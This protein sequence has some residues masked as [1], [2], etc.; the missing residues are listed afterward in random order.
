MSAP[1]QFQTLGRVLAMSASHLKA[2][3]PR[4]RAHVRS[5]PLAT[6]FLKRLLRAET[7]GPFS[8]QSGRQRSVLEARG[9]DE[10][11]TSRMAVAQ[12]YPTRPVRLIV[13]FT[14]GGGNDIVARLIGQWLSER[15]GQPFVIENR[16]G[17]GSNIGTQAVANAPPD[18]Y[19][20]LLCG[21]TNAIN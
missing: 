16:P 21:T 3:S 12:T 19:T 11:S 2:D 20:L 8:A 10:T 5:V 15:L 4:R 9:Y 13:G 14:P 17:A 18:G 6:C 7:S 1:G